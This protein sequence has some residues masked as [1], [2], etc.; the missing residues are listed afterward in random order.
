MH[1]RQRLN[2]RLELL[3]VAGR[4]P[5]RIVALVA[6]T[7]VVVNLL[8]VGIA[9]VT[10]TL[11]AHV[12]V[13]SQRHAAVT[14]AVAPL[15]LLAALLTLDLIARNL[16]TP[17]R[18]WFIH[19]LDGELR[20]KLRRAMARPFGIDHLDEPD[21]RELVGLPIYGIPHYT[22]GSGTDGQMW[23]AARFVGAAAATA[24]L[25]YYFTP[26]VAILSFGL[27]VVQRAMINQQ[28]NDMTPAMSV[29]TTAE[30]GAIYWR[31]IAAGP[32]A[33]KEIRLF[34]FHEWALDQFSATRQHWVD[35]WR[36]ATSNVLPRQWRTFLLSAVAAGVPLVL[37]ARSAASGHLSIADLSIG[38]TSL[39][40]LLQYGLI[41]YEDVSVAGALAALPRLRAIDTSL[42]ADEPSVLSPRM[43][44]PPAATSGAPGIVFEDV[45]FAYPGTDRA[46]LCGLNLVVAQGEHL[47]IVGDN[48]AGKTTLL[49]LLAGFYTPSRGTIR[50]DGIDARELDPQERLKNLAIILQDFTHFELSAYENVALAADHGPGEFDDVVGAA[51]V[52]GALELVEGL[53]RRWETILSKSY[54]GGAELSGGQWQRIALARALFAARRGAKTLIL[55]EPTA[56]LDVEA[57]LTIFDRLLDTAAGLTVLLVS[58][59]FSTVRRADRIVVLGEGR[60]VEEGS[61]EQ[62]MAADGRYAV[63]Y[64]LQADKFAVQDG[65]STPHAG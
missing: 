28:W 43:S 47:A 5:K 37:M 46:V 10:G 18:D 48:G 39:A 22:I 62:L 57:E 2:G 29:I 17:L 6:I 33:A 50:V 41:G 60:V 52:A 16:V 40:A 38:V 15:V 32:G 4:L 54:A 63:L 34:Q 30:E 65:R 64:R 56:N 42:P 31:D 53:P 51:K 19:R 61:H 13:I 27:I 36:H 25:S 7:M 21:V 1:A 44:G 35:M 45:W 59:R 49:K 20:T 26:W 14:S 11:I 23:I 55:D 12:V 9:R 58:H 3:A 24:L 8:P